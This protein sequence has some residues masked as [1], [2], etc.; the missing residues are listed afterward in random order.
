MSDFQ[1]QLKQGLLAGGKRGWFSFLWMAKIV[2]P[3]S[4]V[5][6]LL[7]WTGWLGKIDFL[8]NPLMSLIHLPPEAGYPIITGML[9]NIYAV[10]GIITVLPFSPAQMTLIGVFTLMAHNLPAEGIV[11]HKSGLNIVKSIGVRIILAAVTTIIVSWFLGDTRQSIA[12]A[13]DLTGQAPLFGVLVGWARDTGILLLK[14]FGIIMAIMIILDSLRSLGW[15]EYILRACQPVMKVLGLSGRTTMMWVTA[16]MFGLLYGGAVIAEEAK[17][18]DLKK[19]ELERLHIFIGCNH[20]M[21]EDPALFAVLGLNAF[22]L[23]VPRFVMVV[24]VVHLYRLVGYLRSRLL[25]HP[26]GQAL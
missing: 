3:V 14:I 19:D 4:F 21:I 1:K 12:V 6:V 8:L 2:V 23:W 18:G 16:N 25:S 7:H 9:V 10:I 11:Q 22:W 24:L 15:M 26:A 13:A 20:S 5:V 17:K